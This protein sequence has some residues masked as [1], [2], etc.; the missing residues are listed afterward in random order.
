M[1]KKLWSW[2]VAAIKET[3]NLSNEAADEK[4]YDY[5]KLLEIPDIEK[6]KN[7]SKLTLTWHDP[8]EAKKILQET[9]DLSL[10]NFKRK[11]I[12]ELEEFLTLEKKSKF[13][14]DL[15]RMIYLVEQSKIA[16]ELK[17][18]DSQIS[19]FNISQPSLSLNIN[20]SNIPYYL[21]GYRSIDKEIQLIKNRKYQHLDLLEQEIINFKTFKIDFINYNVY[22]MGSNLLKNTKFIIISSILL[23]LMIGI[24]YVLL[25]NAFQS[26]KLK[27]KDY[28]K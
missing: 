10:I 11:I 23:G 5:I 6:N 22:L 28:K 17:I 7:S 25:L 1:I 19:N 21:R 3:L 27:E 12:N 24:F 2:I 14:K 18:Q 13:S 9:L 20:T 16:K 15:E 4:L 8:E 26:K